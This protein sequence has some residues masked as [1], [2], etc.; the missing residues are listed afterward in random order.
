MNEELM[1]KRKTCE[2]RIWHEEANATELTATT[3]HLTMNTLNSIWKGNIAKYYIQE[4]KLTKP[5]TIYIY[6]WKVS[7][8]WKYD[9]MFYT[10]EL[11]DASERWEGGQW[12]DNILKPEI[13]WIGEYKMSQR[14]LLNTES[15]QD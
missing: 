9:E 11:P 1:K 2:N 4:R 15:Q 8:N 5:W 6:I 14:N 7:E 3:D 10:A 12:K 13:K